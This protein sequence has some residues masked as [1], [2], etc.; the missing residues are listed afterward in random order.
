MSEVDC[1]LEALQKWREDNGEPNEEWVNP[2]ILFKAENP[3]QYAKYR[4]DV[5]LSIKRIVEELGRVR[6]LESFHFLGELFEKE[7]YDIDNERKYFPAMLD[8]RIWLNE[9]EETEKARKI[10]RKELKKKDDIADFA[11]W[12]FPRRHPNYCK[13]PE[14]K[15]YYDI[16]CRIYELY[17]RFLFEKLDPKSNKNIDI[18]GF[19][20][21]K[22]IHCFLNSQGMNTLQEA[23]FADFYM[24]ERTSGLD[25][26]RASIFG[27]FPL[28]TKIPSGKNGGTAFEVIGGEWEEK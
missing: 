1:R 28:K 8:L 23:C 26:P 18:N 27:F 7:R 3:N 4:I 13:D 6:I 9:K 5:C 15:I 14:S 22:I 21:W 16:I 19:S 25:P 10:I 17:C 12:Y 20:N 2:Q 11:F 24:S